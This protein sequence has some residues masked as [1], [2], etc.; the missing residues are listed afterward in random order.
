MKNL[1]LSGCGIRGFY[2]IGL[3]KLLEEK[4]MIKDIENFAGSSVGSIMI[5]MISIGYKYNELYNILLDYNLENILEIDMLNIF[6]NY[7]IYG[8]KKIKNILNI[9]I[10][11][12]CNM[13]NPTFNDLYKLTKKTINIL[14]VNIKTGQHEIFNK[15]ISGEINVC[16]AICASCAIPLLLPCININNNLYID[17]GILYNYPCFVFKDDLRN[18]IGMKVDTIYLKDDINSLTDYIFNLFGLM[19]K[20]LDNNNM[21]P[22]IN[23][24]ISGLDCG[25]DCG[26]ECLNFKINK[27]TKK[28][29][30]NKGYEE[31]KKIIDQ[32]IIDQKKIDQKIK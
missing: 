20:H 29:L 21:E 6:K 28:K 3:L 15:E 7:S 1:V 26:L 12:K 31:S 25:L 19:I 2:Y 27:Y 11:K 17:G 14:T 32:K 18:T 10:K 5:L 24:N 23:I 22:Y 8:N 30:I 9:F 4:N 13:I 16:D